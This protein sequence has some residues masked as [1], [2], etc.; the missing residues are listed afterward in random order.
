[1]PQKIV[2]SSLRLQKERR[3]LLEELGD[4]ELFENDSAAWFTNKT[5]VI[6]LPSCH[7]I[8]TIMS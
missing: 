1:M 6:L 8:R 3:G 7:I 2:F 4:C 5:K